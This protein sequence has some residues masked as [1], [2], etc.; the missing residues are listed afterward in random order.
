MFRHIYITS[1][2][3]LVVFFIL[4]GNINIYGQKVEKGILDLRNT[5]LETPIILDGEW[6]FYYKELLTLSQLNKKKDKK[7][8]K[9]PVLWRDIKDENGNYLSSFGYATYRLR[10]LVSKDSPPLAFELSD[11]YNAYDL[12][13]NGKPFAYN[14]KVGK[15]K[16]DSK[17]HWLPITKIYQVK[18][19]T[20]DLVLQI[21]NF[22]HSK[23]GAQHSIR[24]GNA[25]ELVKAQQVAFVYD[26]L[27]TGGILIAGLFFLGLY[28]FGKHD[29]AILYFSLFSF[30]YLYRIIGY[31]NSLLHHLSPNIPWV[32]TLHLEYL[33]LFLSAYFFLKFVQNLY[34]EEINIRIFKPL[35]WL[36][37]GLVVFTI[38]MPTYIFTN[39]VKYY[40]VVVCMFLL[41]A[42]YVIFQA[43]RHK[44]V[45][46]SYAL[47]SIICLFTAMGSNIY[48]YFS[49]VDLPDSV[50]F[51]FLIAFFFFQS[52]ILS[53]R[54]SVK[55][56]RSAEAAKAADLA[57]S[58]FLAT[59]SHEIRT[60]MNGVI[61]M[62]SLLSDTELTEEQRSFVETIRISGDNLITIINDILDFSKIESGK[63]ELEKQPF[64]LE[65]AI[66]SVCDLL[67]MK[68]YEKGLGL[69]SKIDKDVP[70]IAVGDITRLK[71]VIL[72]LVNNAIKFTYQGEVILKVKKI[73]EEKN[74]VT[75]Q[76]D[77]QDTGIGIPEERM[78][79]LFNAFSQVDASHTRKYGGTGLG[80]VISK[81]LVGLMNG[82]IWVRSEPKK[83]S[84]FSFTVQLDTNEA[85]YKPIAYLQSLDFLTNKKC[86]VITNNQYFL[87]F[88][89]Y[90]LLRYEMQT[91][92]VNT[93]SFESTLH[94]G[95][96][97]DLLV[98]DYSTEHEVKDWTIRSKPAFEN[99]PILAIIP[100]NSN[101]SQFSKQTYLLNLPFRN[102]GLRHM[103]KNIFSVF[104]KTIETKKVIDTK[105]LSERF[106]MKILIVEDHAINQRLVMFLLKKAGYQA[107]AVGNGLEAVEA[108]QRQSYD[109]VF[110]DVQMPE[111]DGLEATKRIV[112]EMPNG[113]R[114]VIVAMTAN[115]MQEDK[116]ECLEAG[117]DDYIT[118]PLK[119]GIVY[120]M[121][122]KW[123]IISR[124]SISEE[125]TKV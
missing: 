92:F 91:T 49:L 44:R 53:Y 78:E 6:E 81:K 39:A 102:I 3:L 24:F 123:A 22:R 76:F 26:S 89:K 61:G 118:K 82:E 84:T 67:S 63:M 40:L 66:E 110:M 104:V 48:E 28:F 30:A 83:G 113:K 11:V 99:I 38:F 97:W 16:S 7:Y 36:C 12:R 87:G 50:Q 70:T 34:P 41:Y 8:E 60:P 43:Y 90:Q 13:I 62:T 85:A 27:M 23:G 69:Y 100:P 108:V 114:P 65:N 51:L 95:E 77:I 14:G 94:N 56:Y 20:L 74:T 71:Q 10:I 119:E 120:E 121:I 125:M 105:T 58:Q 109:L 122:E 93:E 37:I 52:L 2:S 64:E 86:L 46:S 42:L 17:A 57:K 107:D 18:S 80:L 117:M 116:T 112:K 98:I 96:S 88:I 4:Y 33:S 103:L 106:P 73:K 101:R 115:A 9:L 31:D 29:A 124:N 111:L 72:N 21:S 55:L 15:T 1:Y 25:D 32:I 19:D 45:G 35:A 68:A 79:R 54:F 5:S 75:L 47:I 59:M